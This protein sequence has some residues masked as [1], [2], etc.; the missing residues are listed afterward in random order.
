MAKKSQQQTGSRKKGIPDFEVREWNGLNTVIKDPTELKDGES[1]D[2]LNWL[3]SK[4][5]DHI[6]I[7]RGYALLGKTR[8]AA[9]KVTGI[10]VGTKADGTQITFFSFLRK[11]MYYNAATNDIAEIGTDTLYAPASGEDVAF[12]PYQNL[13]GASMFMVSPSSSIFKIMTANPA[14]FTDLK[15]KPTGYAKI[16][17]NRLHM[18]NRRDNVGGKYQNDLLIGRVDQGFALANVPPFAKTTAEAKDTTDGATKTFSNTLNFKATYPLQTAFITEIGAPVAAG[19]NI[20]GISAASSAVVT[21]ASHTFVMGDFVFIDGVVG[22][23]QINNLFGIVLSVTAT[24]ITIAINSASFTAW[25]SGGVIYKAEHFIDDE[26]GVMNS[27]LG[28]TGT[29]NYTTGAYTVNFNTAPLNAKRCYAQ[30]Y[31]ED[32]TNKGVADLTVTSTK[33]DGKLFPQYDGGGALQGVFAFD[34]VQYCLHVTKSWYL[35]L[36]SDDTAASNLPYRSQ[37]GIPYWRAGYATPDGILILDNAI[38]SNPKLKI[39][40]IDAS[41][42]TAILTVVPATISDPLDLTQYGFSTAVVYRFGEMDILCCQNVVNGVVDTLNTIMFVRN[43]YSTQWDKL[44]YPVSC[45]A[46]YL[47]TLIA[48]S[49]LQ[50]NV[51]TLFSGFDDD[52]TPTNNYYITKQYNLKVEGIKRFHRFVIRGLIQQTQN[53]DISLSFDS[54]AFVKV[55]TVSGTGSYVNTGSPT[56]VGSNTVGSQVVG[57]GSG[58]G[59]PVSAYPFEVEF[60]FTS[61]IFEYVQVQFQANNLGYVQIDSFI[62]KDIRYKGRKLPAVRIQSQI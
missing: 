35:S 9:G 44:N 3:T 24:T 25:S 36:G 39:L 54:G 48:G 29:I 22:M 4:Y 13:A 56:V 42:S 46:E 32:S 62:F 59:A 61:D 55:F 28:G 15:I 20:T 51:F 47:G 23:T 50:N 33:G 7:R 57:G 17:T 49:S 31:T 6:E 37:F 40:Q 41:L 43:I 34:Q 16:D 38:S 45:L 14:N 2:S 58:Q 5:K 11:V 60:Q 21:V 10:G 53:I 18:W 52:G 26:N 19:V 8:N 30:Y 1:P 12:M 27:N